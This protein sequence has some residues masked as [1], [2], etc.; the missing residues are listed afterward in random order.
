M[1]G[2]EDE[3]NENLETHVALDYPGEWELLVGVRSADDPA[4]GV[5]TAFAQ[6][7]PDRVRAFLQEGEPGFNPKV[8]QLITLT[9]HAKHEVLAVTDANVRVPRNWL[10]E[11]AAIL[12]MLG[13]GPVDEHLLGRGRADRSEPRSTT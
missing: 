8:N 2:S 10:R 12:S 13:I 5:A 7:H 3:L 1:A 4:W 11:H 6:K 9:R